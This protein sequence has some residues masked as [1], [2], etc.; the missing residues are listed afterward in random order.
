MQ[1]FNTS[2]KYWKDE[3]CT[4]FKGG[5]HE[6]H[7]LLW[8]CSQRIK[9]IPGLMCS[10]LRCQ[11]WL[12][13]WARSLLPSIKALMQPGNF[14]PGAAP[15]PSLSRAMPRQHQKALASHCGAVKGY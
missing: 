2:L 1:L 10:G 7:G 13:V 4:I 8:L 5:Q 11:L 3:Q 12:S 9:N 6:H 15:L 14:C